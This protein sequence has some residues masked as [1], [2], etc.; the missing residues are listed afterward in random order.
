MKVD[1][2]LIE[3]LAQRFHNT[4]M[5]EN[6]RQGR[7][8]VD[9]WEELPAAVKEYDKAFAYQ[10]IEWVVKMQAAMEASLRKDLGIE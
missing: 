1:D 4:W 2:K 3:A 9:T 10:V 6:D 7:V 5:R 8:P